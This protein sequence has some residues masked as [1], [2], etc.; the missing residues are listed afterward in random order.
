MRRKLFVGTLGLAAWCT[1]AWALAPDQTPAPSVPADMG[2]LY[3]LSDL[4]EVVDPLQNWAT[5]PSSDGDPA[6]APEVLVPSGGAKPVV[7][8]PARP[9]GPLAAEETVVHYSARF[10]PPEGGRANKVYLADETATI[11]AEYAEIAGAVSDSWGYRDGATDGEHVFFGW[12]GG[13]AQHD[14]DGANGTLLISG[15]A[16]EGVG[17]WRALAYNPDGD[18]GNGS[19]WS[20]SF[21]SKL[22][23][24]NMSG[25]VLS[26]FDNCGYS[27]Y[28]LA[29][30]HSTGN[31]WGHSRG[32]DAAEVVEIDTSDGCVIS[33]PYSSHFGWPGGGENGKAIQGG[34]SM[35]DDTGVL[36]GVLQGTPDAGWSADKNIELTPPVDPNPRSLQA[37]TDNPGHLGVAVVAGGEPEPECSDDNEAYDAS[38]DGVDLNGQGGFYNPDP[39]NSVS[40]KV[41]TYKDNVLGIP[42]NPSGGGNNF[43][44]STGPAGGK[45]SRSQKDQKYGE[46]TGKWVVAFDI[47]GVYLGDLPSAQNLGSLSTQTFPGDATFIALAR[48]SDPNT[49]ENWNADVVWFNAGGT[50]LIE[51]IPDAG[52]QNLKTKH[53]YRWTWEFDLDSYK[54]TKVSIEDLSTGVTAT[55]EPPDRYLFGGEGGAP[56][57]DGFRYFAGASGVAGNTLAFDNLFICAAGEPPACEPGGEWSDNFDSYEE[58]SNMI[59]QGCWEGWF[60]DPGA[61]AVV[62]AEKAFSD[63]HS[64]KTEGASDL[65]YE[66]LGHTSGQWTLSAQWY[67]P[68]GLNAATFFIVNNEYDGPGGTA[69]WAIEVSANTNGKILDDFRPEANDID[70]AFD[71]WAE[72]RVEADLDND[73]QKTYY[74]CQ[75]L[76]EG[77]WAIR[78]GAV[79]MINLDLFSN[80]PVAYFDDI[81][82]TEGFPP[83]CGACCLPDG[84]CVDGLTEDECAAEGGVAWH[85]GVI[86]VP[87]LCKEPEPWACCLPDLSC[88]MLLE[89]DC[90]ARDG[91]WNEDL[92][93]DEVDC[94]GAC[95]LPEDGGGLMWFSTKDEFEAAAG[96]QIC[97]E[98]YE[99]S[100]LPPNSVA[101]LADPLCSG[102]PHT[103][104]PNGLEGCDDMCV[105]SNL[106]AGNP[107]NPDPRGAGGI[108]IASVGFVGA[109]SDI[110][111]ANSFLDSFDHMFD[112]DDVGAVGANTIDALGDQGGVDVRVYDIDNNLLGMEH[113]AANIQGTNFF[114]VVSDGATIGRVNVYSTGAS[115]AEGLDN[116]QLHAGGEP[117]SCLELTEEEC[118]EK[119]GSWNKGETCDSGVCEEKPGACCRLSDHSCELTLEDECTDSEN[120]EWHEGKGCDEVECKGECEYIVKRSKAKHG[121]MNCWAPGKWFRAEGVACDKVKDCK[122]RIKGQFECESRGICK[123]KG[124]RSLCEHSPP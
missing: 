7:F 77:K 68:S 50:Q 30:D 54:I 69:Q 38:P 45:F 28:G 22:I 89:D 74:N 37:Q 123:F 119:E 108:A 101:G 34:L 76:S 58:G 14:R 118:A 1:V 63:P 102:V 114:G 109:V 64:V 82:Q 91:K 19:L 61:D 72:I 33:G 67:I 71:E 43:V 105:Q 104:Y 23:E 57:P 47:A 65:V 24:V 70:V 115:G 83:P 62:S 124:K 85:E 95:C 49:A 78:G 53:W 31:L 32:E 106:G 59:G 21:A 4:A 97:L 40:G 41:Y 122:R 9:G 17:T 87:E 56:P 15:P 113:F 79:E 84:D 98:D 18:G 13:V 80:G 81:T 66:Y 48:W 93:C 44:G 86:C 75:L 6:F 46:G 2:E 111:I 5:A 55:Y 112:R 26:S 8:P 100:T 117:P 36:Y 120:A 116:I 96:D 42:D 11:T 110:V 20:A 94:G 51:V 88:E 27:L 73:T 10:I 16:P 29:F 92:T 107:E 99:E 3:R 35:N 25:G 39:P 60:R 103:N 12:G 121:C 90:L 52:F